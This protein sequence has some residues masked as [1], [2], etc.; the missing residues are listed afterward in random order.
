MAIC[1][2]K[3]HFRLAELAEGSAVL[4]AYAPDVGRARVS[5]IR[6]V[7]GRTTDRVKITLARDAAP[8]GEPVTTGGVAITLG[9]TAAGLEGPEV[10]VVAV[11]DASEAERAGLVAND[12]IVEVAGVVPKSMTDAR[13]RLSGPVQDD[14]LVKVR[15]GDRTL[16]LRVPRE[17][18]RR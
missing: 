10:V 16:I 13:A 18:V 7:S 1:D 2:S 12:T 5:G 11:A 15:R 17:A 14:V 8:S 4:E 9:E 3:G 6:V